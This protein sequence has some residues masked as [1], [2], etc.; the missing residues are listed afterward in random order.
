MT[1]RRSA[2]THALIGLASSICWAAPALAQDRTESIELGEAAC[3]DCASPADETEARSTSPADTATFASQSEDAFAPPPSIPAPPP[4]NYNAKLLLT[5]AVS[6]IDGGSGGGI[7]SWA[8]IAGRQSDRGFGVQGHAT[9]ITLPDYEWTSFGVAVG[10]ADRL[11]LSYTRQNFDTQDVGAALGIGQGYVLNQ[12][13]FGAKLRVIGDVVYGDPL[14]PQ[15][16]AGVQYKRSLDGPIAAAVGADGD[17]GVDFTLSA[18]K[19]FLSHSVLINTTARL[20]K[21]N[22]NGLL[23]FGSAANDYSLQ[24]EGS[25][26]YQL[27][28]RFVIGTEVRTK[29]DNLGLGEDDWLDVFAAWGV[30]DNVTLTA[31]YADLGSIATFED[32]RGAFLQAQ[33]AF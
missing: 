29:P 27:S 30:T 28:R 3:F 5:N 12:D 23:G 14:L 7:A 10:V 6:P 31:A 18:T 8:T 20:T 17:E 15:I 22:Q 2:R 1:T 32:Q 19:L 11:E 13:V 26:A 9:Y 24:F 4:A 16:S 21:A 33:I 25:L